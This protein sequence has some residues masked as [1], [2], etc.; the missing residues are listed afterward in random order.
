MSKSNKTALKPTGLDTHTRAVI[1]SLTD[2]VLAASSELDM[3]LY[4]TNLKCWR[5]LRTADFMEASMGLVPDTALSP[6]DGVTFS[7]DLVLAN[8]SRSISDLRK[9]ARRLSAELRK[10]RAIREAG[11]EKAND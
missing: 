10:V 5:A 4:N 1:R 3:F 8:A 2:R 6:F 11:N 9:N 7:V